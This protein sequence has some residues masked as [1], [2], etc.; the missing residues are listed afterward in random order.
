MSPDT[1][2]YDT[3]TPAEQAD[4]DAALHAEARWWDRHHARSRRRRSMVADPQWLDPR[5]AIATDLDGWPL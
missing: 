4:L 5:D 2:S 1:G 3:L